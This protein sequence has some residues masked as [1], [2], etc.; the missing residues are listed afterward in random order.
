MP[1]NFFKYIQRARPGRI[2][3]GAAPAG[4][5][6]LEARA[7]LSASVVTSFPGSGP[8][9]WIPPDTMG[10]VGPSNLMEFINDQV[11][12]RDKSG[13]ALVTESGNTFWANA[14]VANVGA[15]DSRI[16]YDPVSQRWFASSDID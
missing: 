10:A 11:V 4:L 2:R 9:G 5:E 13:N 7:Y 1:T 3:R 12:I 6:R 8:N 15:Y 16:A 14:G